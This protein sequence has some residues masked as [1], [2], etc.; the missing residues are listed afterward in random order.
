MPGDESRR[1]PLHVALYY[2]DETGLRHQLAQWNTTDLAMLPEEAN[3]VL[4][5]N[6]G[7]MRVTFTPPDPKPDTY[8]LV[9]HGDM[10]EEKAPRDDRGNICRVGP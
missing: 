8:L 10:G 2:D 5:K 4:A 3:G 1:W 7:E 9:F 6:G